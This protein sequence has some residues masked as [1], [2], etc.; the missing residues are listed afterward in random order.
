MTLRSI[1][2]ASLTALLA[3]GFGCAPRQEALV[4]LDVS[5]DANVPPALPQKLA[6]LRFSVPAR[7]DVPQKVEDGD[8]R[9]MTLHFGYYMAGVS[10]TVEILGEAIDGSGCTVGTGRATVKNVTPGKTTPAMPL[11]ISPSASSC[12]ATTTDG[13][14]AG[15]DG[16]DAPPDVSPGSDSLPAPDASDGPRDQALGVSD[17]PRDQAPDVSDGARDQT[18]EG[19][20]CASN[21]GQ[22]CDTCGGTYTCAGVC[23]NPCGSES[24]CSGTCVDVTIS[25]SHCGSCTRFCGSGICQTSKCLDYFGDRTKGSTFTCTPNLS[26]P[27]ELKQLVTIPT[28]VTL[29]KLGVIFSSDGASPYQMFIYASATATAPLAQT[30]NFFPGPEAAIAGGPIALPAGDYYIS[31]KVNDGC[32]AI[33]Q[34][35]LNVYA[36]VLD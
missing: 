2:Q 30:G 36:V 8:P 7:A 22:S 21:F 12:P 35:K 19:P 11:T 29:E 27:T 3:L 15:A 10:G 16:I 20:S 33:D 9:P 28:A 13:G 5:V 31:I 25:A 4:L 14:D 26:I 18:P 34:G 17:G 1:K 24:C 32:V 23:S 6:R